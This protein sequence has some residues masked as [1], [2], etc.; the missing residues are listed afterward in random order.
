MENLTLKVWK[1]LPSKVWKTLPTTINEESAFCGITI[2]LFI[3]KITILQDS[4]G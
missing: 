2:I 1:T 4:E 3:I